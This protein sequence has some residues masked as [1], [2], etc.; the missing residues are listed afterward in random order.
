MA[1]N[2]FEGSRRIA[3]ITASIWAIGWF[4]VF[5]SYTYWAYKYECSIITSPSDLAGD[6][7]L[8]CGENN[9]EFISYFLAT[10]DGETYIAL[11]GFLLFICGLT[12][13]VGCIVRG[14]MGIPRGQ[15]QKN[16]L[17]IKQ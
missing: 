7:F 11:I 13:V 17:I 16:N 6:S 14:F 8:L 15:D 2:I 5:F 10:T 3:K 12:W 4:C 9:Q 1:T